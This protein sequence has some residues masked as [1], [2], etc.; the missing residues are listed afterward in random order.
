LLPY[1]LPSINSKL[2]STANIDN[3]KRVQECLGI[4]INLP[5]KKYQEKIKKL[6]YFAKKN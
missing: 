1:R 3:Y 5:K 6:R 2:G 4:L